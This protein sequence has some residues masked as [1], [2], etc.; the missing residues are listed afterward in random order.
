MEVEKEEWK[1]HPLYRTKTKVQLEGDC[2]SLKIP[3]TTSL[4][5]HELVNLIFEKRAEPKRAEPLPLYSG[6]LSS[7]P[8]TASGLQRLT[9]PKLIKISW[10]STP[11]RKR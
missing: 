10:C 11:R 1:T 8:S 6:N 3:V 4:H 2:R 7:L 5:K 9:I